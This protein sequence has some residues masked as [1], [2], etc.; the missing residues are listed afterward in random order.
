MINRKFCR[1]AQLVKRFLHKR[2]GLS[3]SG[4]HINL[5]TAAVPSKQRQD[6]PSLSHQSA[7][8]IQ[9]TPDSA[10]DPVSNSKVESR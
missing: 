5:G 8:L 4:T 7:L 2:E 6:H 10:G 9:C 3:S 1:G